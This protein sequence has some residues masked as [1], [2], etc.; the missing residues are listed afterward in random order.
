VPELFRQI[1]DPAPSDRG[2]R[3]SAL[4][5]SVAV[6]VAVLLAI[7]VIPL[8]ASDVLPLVRGADI[9][10]TPIVL[11]TVPPALPQPAVHRQA[12]LPAA[13]APPVEPP[14]GIGRERMIVAT[15]PPDT[16]APGPRGV[17]DGTEVP[18]GISTVV[19][20]APPPPRAA[21]PVRVSTLLRPP[22]RLREVSPVYPEAAR[23][24]RVE[25]V[26]IIEAIISPTGEVVD[27]RVLRSRPLLDEAALV[28]VR[29]WR[30]TPS[31]LNGVPVPVVMTVTVN[32]TLR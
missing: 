13:D 10:W 16:A 18:G 2:G 19:P 24:A 4:P 7:V 26:V 22:V 32:F 11:P 3:V 12:A 14:T 23:M 5:V 9:A 29:Q 30:Y 21:A 17:V 15:E 27:A 6:H 1:A 8:L 28:A 25:G 20:D 31:L